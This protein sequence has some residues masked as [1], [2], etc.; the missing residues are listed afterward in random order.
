MVTHLEGQIIK[1]VTEARTNAKLSRKEVADRL[2]LEE[3]SYGHYERGRFAFTVEML[4]QLSKILGKPIEWLLGLPTEMTPDEQ[5][6][7]ALYRELH[8]DARRMFL[9]VTRQ[10]VKFAN[11][12]TRE[13]PPL[14]SGETNTDKT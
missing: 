11:R 7:L 6:M 3:Q 4:F 13:K 1:R 10:Q 5:E 2:N 14:S 12:I 9:E 8:P